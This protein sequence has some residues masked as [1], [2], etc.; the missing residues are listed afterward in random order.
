MPVRTTGISEKARLCD[1]GIDVDGTRWRGLTW[2]HYAWYRDRAAAFV[3]VH[4]E[5]E[6]V[7]L[8]RAFYA[9]GRETNDAQT[10]METVPPTVCCAKPRWL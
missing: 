1:W 2:Q 10:V 7:D 9:V 8:E 3:T 6:L 5:F 4:P